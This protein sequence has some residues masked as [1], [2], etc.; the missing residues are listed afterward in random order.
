MSESQSHALLRKVA[1]STA[2]MIS[3]AKVLAPARM[4]IWSALNSA[5]ATKHM[6]IGPANNEPERKSVYELIRKVRL[7]TDMVLLDNEAYNIYAGVRSTQKIQGD[8]AEVGV[9]RGGSA[10]LIA[11]AKGAR[12]LHLFDTFEGLPETRESDPLFSKGQFSSSKAAVQRYLEPYPN[13]LLYEGV[14]PG[15]AGPIANTN[16]SFVHLDV[17]IYES[18]AKSLEFFYPRMSK[19]GVLISH[20]YA[21]AEGVKRAFVEFFVD[22]A[23]PILELGGSQCAFT[24]IG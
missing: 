13:V 2:S 21:W 11:E 20:D 10:K 17:D 18:T 22:K 16:F 8:I 9:F 23:E 1:A 24:K 3:N 15:T 4:A 5:L 7:E 6:T 14:F 19:G 12:T